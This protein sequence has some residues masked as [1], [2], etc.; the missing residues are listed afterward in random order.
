M[1]VEKILQDRDEL[2]AIVNKWSDEDERLLVFEKDDTLVLKKM[3]WNLSGFADD[4]YNDEMSM[5]EIVAE[6]HRNRHPGSK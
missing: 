4:S 5:E 1:L 6:V 3:K 2:I